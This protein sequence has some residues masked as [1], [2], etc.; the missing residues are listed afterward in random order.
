MKRKE[1][2]AKAESLG[3]KVSVRSDVMKS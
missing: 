1:A 3:V 2:Q